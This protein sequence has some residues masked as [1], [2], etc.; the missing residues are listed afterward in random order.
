MRSKSHITLLQP[1][2]IKSLVGGLMT[3]NIFI[4]DLH[5]WMTNILVLGLRAA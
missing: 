4:L 3:T 2:Y 5:A 1:V